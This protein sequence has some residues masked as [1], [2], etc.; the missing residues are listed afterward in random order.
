MK[1][2]L[3]N[4]ND[5]FEIKGKK[6]IKYSGKE[7]IVR[8]PKSVT[9]IEAKA[10]YQNE[11]IEKV[12]LPPSIKRIGENAFD[13]CRNLVA[14]KLPKSLKKIG[15]ESFIG[16]SIKEIVLPSNLEK[17]GHGAFAHCKKLKRIIFPKK[18]KFTS[19]PAAFAAESPLEEIK[20][21]EGV[22]T[23]LHHAFSGAEV[24]H[25]PKSL[26]Y[27]GEYAFERAERIYVRTQKLFFRYSATSFPEN[28][29]FKYLFTTNYLGE[30]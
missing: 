2:I 5:D 3:E 10:F 17:I 13:Y 4:L 1:L 21:P 18:S 11:T 26:S 12:I 8:V 14:I 6:L 25:L 23:I 16:T 28:T 9:T 24:V 30:Y 27:V 22:D 15:V 29:E 7:K 20:I 19:I